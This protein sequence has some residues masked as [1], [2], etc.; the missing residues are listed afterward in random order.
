MSYNHKNK[1]LSLIVLFV[2]GGIMYQLPL[3]RMLF[4]EQMVDGMNLNSSQI[5]VLGAAF[6]VAA[7]ICYFPGGWLADKFSC[8][9]LIAFSFLMNGI[10]GFYYATLPSFKIS[11]ALNFYFGVFSTITYWAALIKA[12]GMLGS[13]NESSKMLGILEG[14]RGITSTIAGII[15]MQIFNMI[16]G[17]VFGL[18]AVL[19]FY[20]FVYLICSGL[21]WFV[22]EDS[23][24][25]GVELEKTSVTMKELLSVSKDKNVWIICGVIFCVY[26]IYSAQAYI[27]PYL[28]DVFGMTV[29]LG[30]ILNII[31]S[32]VTQF[33]GGPLGGVVAQKMGSSSKFIRVSILVSIA[34][35]ILF[36]VMPQKPELIIIASINVVILMFSNYMARGVYFSTIQEVN[37]RPEIR[38][39]ASGFASFIGFL[40]EI[41]TPLV[42]GYL[43]DNFGNNGYKFM[44]I[45]ILITL[46]CG[47][48]FIN[49]LIHNIRKQKEGIKNTEN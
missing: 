5:G 28:T 13:D 9:K 37:I 26:T 47:L 39:S 11:V 19:V 49:L 45:Y 25:P 20:S 2:G 1:W 18:Q 17:K 35:V 24:A 38:G 46:L 8:R 36:L 15:A 12:T 41:L 22:L 42:I 48:I 29:S 4:Y 40:P 23:D 33:T 21:S 6:G 43:I 10:G 32:Y 27:T 16:G 34:S 31:R 14:G 7:T 30:L 3:L 44:Y